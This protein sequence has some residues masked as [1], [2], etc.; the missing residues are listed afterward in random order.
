MFY[1][2]S[3][4]QYQGLE[5]PYSDDLPLIS[6][7]NLISNR[8]KSEQVPP[9]RQEELEVVVIEICWLFEKGWKGKGVPRPA[10]RLAISIQ[11]RNSLTDH[12]YLSFSL[13]RNTFCDKGQ[14][15]RVKCPIA[16]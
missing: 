15:V 14:M 16:L 10:Y 6:G 1:V 9:D 4:L 2:L 3:E 7:K 5:D 8:P 13:I 12:V 11:Q